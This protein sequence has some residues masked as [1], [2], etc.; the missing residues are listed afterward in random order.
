M[1][2]VQQLT[3]QAQPIDAFLDEI[4]KEQGQADLPTDV[5]QELK[6]DLRDRLNNLLIARFTAALSDTQIDEFSSLLDTNPSD[7]Q[8]QEFFTKHIEKTDEVV[9]QTLLDFRNTY[10]SAAS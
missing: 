5:Y 4:L 6:N 7:E 3:N 8:I 10:L 2:A 9:A 1:D